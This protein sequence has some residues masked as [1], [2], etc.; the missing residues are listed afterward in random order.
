MN[1]AILILFVIFAIVAGFIYA[2]ARNNIAAAP[3]A[4]TAASILSSE[5]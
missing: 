1:K 5:S 2:A 3:Q 4:E